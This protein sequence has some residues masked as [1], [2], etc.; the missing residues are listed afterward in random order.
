[1]TEPDP[2]A[3]ADAADRAE[4]KQP[5]PTVVTPRGVLTKAIAGYTALRLGLVVALAV[6][7]YFVPQLAGVQIPLIVAVLLAVVLQLPMAWL[8]FERQR[9]R[10]TGLMRTAE[11]RGERD[12]LRAALAGTDEGEKP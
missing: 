10:L 8:L 9:N 7:L 2:P 1:V 11:R 5:A 3:A 12:R 4:M 6:F